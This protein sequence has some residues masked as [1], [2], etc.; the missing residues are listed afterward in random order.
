VLAFRPAG[1]L[2]AAGLDAGALARPAGWDTALHFGSLAVVVVAFLGEYGFR[3]CWLRH[4]P[5]VSLPV[6]IVRLVRAWPA[7]VQAARTGTPA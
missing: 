7:V 3:R 2:D 4:V 5:H 1:W 6:F